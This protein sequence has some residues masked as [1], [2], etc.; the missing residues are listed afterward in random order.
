V[1][2]PKAVFL[3][4]FSA[5]ETDM[6]PNSMV[7]N[8]WLISR[9]RYTEFDLKTIGQTPASGPIKEYQI[10]ELG[11]YLLNP[12]PFE[13]KKRLVGCEVHYLQ[14]RTQKTKAKVWQILPSNI[15][16]FKKQAPH[17]KEVFIPQ[18]DASLP[19]IRDNG[20]ET[21]LNKIYGMLKN[22]DPIYK[23]LA[24][25]DRS[26]VSDIV[27]ICEDIDGNRS[28]LNLTGNVDQ[29]IDFV[30]THIFQPVGVIIKQAHI[31][32]G[33]FEMRGFEFSSFNPE[34]TWRLLQYR[35]NGTRHACVL[36]PGHTVA[37]WLADPDI[38]RAMHLV[39]QSLKTCTLL[40]DCLAGCN[41]G[42]AMP[43]KLFIKKDM[44]IQYT[45]THLPK[46]YQEIF[47]QMGTEPTQKTVVLDTLAAHQI[48]VAFS[49]MPKP[50]AV[51]KKMVTSISVLHDFR[52]L[53][54]LKT[55]APQ[56]Y[57]AMDSRTTITE[58]G[59]YYLLDA[60]QGYQNV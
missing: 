18:I 40:R 5:C 41:T 3:W 52:A 47:N 8:F 57:A 29:K 54:P 9:G 43:F 11:Y 25:L 32:E 15:N 19:A 27:G 44:A 33:L 22:Y 59:K 56:I 26:N 13:I 6:P 58:A 38:I 17:K 45:D 7:Q 1:E 16:A 30:G 60:I 50:V 10:S 14:H 2:L 55:V 39:D 24:R 21:H 34:T 12:N 48:G 36:D 42:Q 28:P 51:E 23:G 35:H 4:S 46:V 53:Q 37:F 20:L 31:A 49:F